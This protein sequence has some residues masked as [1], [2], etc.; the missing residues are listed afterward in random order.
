MIGFCESVV[1]PI[2]NSNQH[3]GLEFQNTTRFASTNN[4][5]LFESPL[6]QFSAYFDYTAPKKGGNALGMKALRWVLM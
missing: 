4:R 3:S 5:L 1:K 6:Q 2:L